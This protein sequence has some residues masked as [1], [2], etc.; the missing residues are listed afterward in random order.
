MVTVTEAAARKILE[1]IAEE[2]QNVR[3]DLALRLKVQAG[4]CSGLQYSLWLEDEIT[5][6]DE[7]FEDRGVK[8]VIDRRELPYVRGSEIDYSEDDLTRMGFRINNPN[9]QGTC[10]CGQSFH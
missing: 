7:D 8:I 9:A 5:E 3:T 2:E 1:M 4:G 10:S 6:D